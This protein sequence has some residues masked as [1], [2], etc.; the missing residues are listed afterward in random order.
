MPK[1][2]DKPLEG[3]FV[4]DGRDSSTHHLGCERFLNAEAV[5]EELKI[6][7]ELYYNHNVLNTNQNLGQP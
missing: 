4:E 2:V 6:C 5:I 1:T 7:G 3:H